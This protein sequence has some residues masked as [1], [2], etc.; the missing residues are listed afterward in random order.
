MTGRDDGVGQGGDPGMGGTPGTA[1]GPDTLEFRYSRQ[2]RLERAPEIVRETYRKGYTPNKG[3][4]RGLTAT[5]GLRSIFFAIIILS[6]VVVG[7][8]LFGGSS[9]QKTLNGSAV[10]LTAFLY[11]D[12][13]YVSVSLKPSGDSAAPSEPVPVSAYIEGL[14]ASGNVVAEQRVSGAYAGSDTVL[15]AVLRDYELLKVRCEVLFG[16]AAAELSASVDRN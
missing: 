15:R 12:S 5:P 6:A 16:D 14:D 13:V 9:D 4:I 8:T 2:K 7:V 10:R 1:E 3:F 11:G